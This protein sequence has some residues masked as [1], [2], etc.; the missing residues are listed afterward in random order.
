[1]KFQER[2]QYFV[3]FNIN[4]R[5]LEIDSWPQNSFGSLDINL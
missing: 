5:N 1:M 4:E 3:L 2:M